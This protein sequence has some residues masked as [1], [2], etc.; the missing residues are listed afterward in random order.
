MK[1]VLILL[2]L[3]L[4]FGTAQTEPERFVALD[5]GGGAHTGHYEA[6][7]SEAC[8]Y[9]HNWDVTYSVYLE[10]P[11][12][13]SPDTFGL[14]RL[15]VPDENDLTAFTLVAGFGDYGT[16]DYTE[17]TLE[18]ATGSGTGLL[19]VAKTGKHAALTITGKTAEGV[20]LTATFECLDV[21]DTSGDT[22][23]L[24]DLALSF[25]PDSD[26]PT[27]LLELSV[28]GQSYRVQTGS[29]ASCDRH[30]VE[31]VDLWYEYDPGG[32]YTGVMLIVPDLEAAKGGTSSFGFSLDLHPYYQN[33]DS[34]GKLT[35]TQAGDTLTLK[36]EL[37]DADGTPL[38]AT[39]TCSSAD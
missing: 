32:S 11:S 9:D 21:L 35:D 17:Y 3:A 22:P 23:P 26:M 25:P 39:I 24:G 16:P 37:T 1:S 36:A 10:H 12:G 34:S 13:N 20:E 29:E 31:G 5:L 15:S 7:D 33:G 14:L 27:G 8:L 19:E 30:V 6:K 2:Y 18:P 38:T 4:A 28:G